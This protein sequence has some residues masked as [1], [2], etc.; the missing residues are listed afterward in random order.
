MRRAWLFFAVAILFVWKAGLVWT[1]EPK[2]LQIYSVDVEGGQAT[3]FVS[4]S[5]ASMLVDAGFPGTRDADRI[6]AAAADAGVSQIDYFVNT[7]L[8]ADHF[9]SIPDLVTRVPVRNFIDNGALAE[10]AERSVAA[11]RTYAAVR[12]RSPHTVPKPGDKVP[13]AGLDVQVVIA[14][15][16][17]AARLAGGGAPNPLCRDWTPLEEDKSEDA[18]SIGVIV[19]HGSF[20]MLDLGDLTWNKEHLLVCPDNLIGPVDVYL[21]TRHGL[22]GT[23]SPVA[24]HAFR[25]RVAV[26]N[27]AGTK[28]ASREHWMTVQSSPGLEDMWQLHLSM[29]RAGMSQLHETADQGGKDVNAPEQFIANVNDTTAH[30]L[31]ITV[32]QDGGFTVTNP[33]NGFSKSYRAR[34]NGD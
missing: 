17:P 23:G 31:K 9:G 15:G 27:N 26:F 13:I 33:R 24:V 20:R 22:N 3:L 2:P 18:R 7:H 5:G 30:F 21:T 8:H 19:R 4:P 11:F 25:P 16:V 1:Q 12:D 32:R 34:T 6:A 14:G 29:P 10:T 28:G